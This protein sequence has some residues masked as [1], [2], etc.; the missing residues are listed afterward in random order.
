M[1]RP[2]KAI[3][4]D[5]VFGALSDPIRRAILARLAQGEC[6][7][8]T[9]AAPFS[10]S[11][12]AISKH[13]RVLESSG[14]ITRRIEGRMHYCRFRAEELRRANHWIEQQQSFWERQ[15]QSLARYLAEEQ[16]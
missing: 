13:L 2:R 5:A 11:A 16:E 3:P 15:F 10:V 12:P 6:P 1:R 8:T 9:L 14:L 7:V 4:L